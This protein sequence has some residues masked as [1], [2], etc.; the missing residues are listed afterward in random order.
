M[1]PVT[2]GFVAIL[3]SVNGNLSPAEYKEILVKTSYRRYYKGVADFEDGNAE[4][5]VDIGKAVAYLKE[6]YPAN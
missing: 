2:A 1:S 6:N 4:H 3:K 5:V